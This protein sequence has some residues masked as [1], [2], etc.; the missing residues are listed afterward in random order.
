MPH[1]FPVSEYY[2]QHVQDGISITRSGGWWTA[3]LLFEDPETSIRSLKLYRWKKKDGV[4]KNAGSNIPFK[5]LEV[6]T[7]MQEALEEL[8]ERL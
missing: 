6:I 1:Q 4:W 5:N 8:S 3:L 7:R 2:H